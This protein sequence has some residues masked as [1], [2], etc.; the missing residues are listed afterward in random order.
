MAS[1]RLLARKLFVDT[2]ADRLAQSAPQT[3]LLVREAK[4]AF[5]RRHHRE[6]SLRNC[7]EILDA[8]PCVRPVAPENRTLLR[9]TYNGAALGTLA[10]D[11]IF[12]E[13]LEIAA[14]HLENV[15]ELAKQVLQ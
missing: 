8:P 13:P 7:I 1:H 15:H 10:S 12:V 5:A 4:D 14:E 11:Y 9:A 6:T 2:L 3:L